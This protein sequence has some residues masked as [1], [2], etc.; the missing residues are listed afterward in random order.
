MY[1][2]INTIYIYRDTKCMNGDTI[3]LKGDTTDMNT[4]YNQEKTA[5]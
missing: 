2:N 1:M 5:Y 4:I 3:Y